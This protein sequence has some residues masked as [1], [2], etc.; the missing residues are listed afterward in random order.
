MDITQNL[1]L[2]WYESDVPGQKGDAK[3]FCEA[4]T[5]LVTQIEKTVNY[6][7][8]IHCW[9]SSKRRRHSPGSSGKKKPV[10]IR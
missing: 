5:I 8:S 4:R 2:I 1:Q 9:D 3:C 6:Y 10:Q 7:W